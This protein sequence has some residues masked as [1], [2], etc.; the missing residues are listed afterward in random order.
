MS[1]PPALTWKCSCSTINWANRAKCRSWR[2]PRP[3]WEQPKPKQPKKSKGDGR[4]FRQPYIWESFAE[5]GARE[6][7]RDSSYRGS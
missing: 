6:R 1:A 3:Q 4:K 7:E 5:G 2:A